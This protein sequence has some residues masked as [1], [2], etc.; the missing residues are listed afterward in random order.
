M[1]NFEKFKLDGIR[2]IICII[3]ITF[4]FQIQ[5]ITS[6][7]SSPRYH[8]GMSFHSFFFSF[9]FNCYIDIQ[10]HRENH[11]PED[12][13]FKS[14]EEKISLIAFIKIQQKRGESEPKKE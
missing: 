13:F 10:F 14:K 12:I 4:N 9:S 1:S 3:Y 7:Y 8:T 2:E 11:V 6:R 5:I